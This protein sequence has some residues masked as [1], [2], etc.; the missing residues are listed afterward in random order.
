MQSSAGSPK[1]IKRN[2]LRQRRR[3]LSPAEHD[4]ASLLAAETLSKNI[5]LEEFRTV[6]GYI[7]SDGEIDPAP[8]L[9]RFRAIGAQILLPR[10][11][12]DNSLELAP[13]GTLEPTGPAGILEPTGPGI[14]PTHVSMPALLLVP[15]VGLTSQGG[16]LGRGG[17]F[18][19]RFLPG[20]RA[21]DWTICGL[22]H[23]ADLLP[24]LP[25]EEH[26]QSV[27]WCLTEK[28]LVRIESPR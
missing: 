22:C 21:A 19:D 16:R 12:P 5:N 1:A 8:L 18:Y 7:A 4:T 24:E 2:A 6:A 10:T 9:G 20:L 3:G 25:L 28:R 23:D 15:S 13:E 11:G 17:G 27:T 14:Q 26:D